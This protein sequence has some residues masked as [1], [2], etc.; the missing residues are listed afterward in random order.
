[1]I[2]NGKAWKFGSNV[3]ATDIVSS[4]YD[5][6]GMSKQWPECSKHLFEALAPSFVGSAQ[7]G[8]ILVAGH[9]L[10]AGHAHYY[11]TAIMACK[12]A[13]LAGFFA[14]TVNNL[15]QRAAIDQ[16]FPIW[17]IPGLNA[18]LNTGDALELDL[19]A[20]KATNFS[21]GS[22]LTFKPVSSI[23]LDI[24]GADGSRNWALRRTNA[25]PTANGPIQAGTY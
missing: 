1:M 2:L 6:F 23:I 8:D 17:Q 5:K 19:L 18:I 7:P 9:K 3:G 24:L 22:V 20:G 13:G 12:A 16:G 25:G 10:G 14:E 4:E 21:N 15:F 11:T